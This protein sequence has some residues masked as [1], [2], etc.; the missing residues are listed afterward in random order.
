[1]CFFGMECNRLN[2]GDFKFILKQLEAFNSKTIV[3]N[4]EVK[5][6]VSFINVNFD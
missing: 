1:M 2:Q 3:T 5:E 4:L 6:M